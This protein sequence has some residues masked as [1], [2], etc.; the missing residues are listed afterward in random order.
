M[1][2]MLLYSRRRPWTKSSYS[3]SFRKTKA[4]AGISDVTFQ[5]LHGTFIARR[6]GECSCLEIIA[7]GMGSSTKDILKVLEKHCLAFNETRSDAVI[8]RTKK[9]NKA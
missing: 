4:R 9:K 2:R 1:M 5:D 8:L 7:D 3:A 6:R